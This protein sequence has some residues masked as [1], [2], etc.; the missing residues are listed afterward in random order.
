MVNTGGQV[1]IS[2]NG[3]YRGGVS[4][5]NNSWNV[6]KGPV[7]HSLISNAYMNVSSVIGNMLYVI[8]SSIKQ[9]TNQNW[10]FGTKPPIHDG[11][12]IRRESELCE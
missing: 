4:I 12:L 2:Q 1:I 8:L 11:S 5:I 3:L 10:H 7:L 6:Q 9:S